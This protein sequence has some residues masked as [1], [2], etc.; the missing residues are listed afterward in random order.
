MT[1][2]REIEAIREDVAQLRADI[3]KLAGKAGTI[4][5]EVTENLIQQAEDTIEELKARAGKQYNR[6]AKDGRRYAKQAEK[7]IQQSVAEHPFGTA[8][9]ALAAGVILA[10]LMGRSRSE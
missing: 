2:T 10:Q 7:T 9:I 5:S 6:L 1:G 4:G 8:V 3:K